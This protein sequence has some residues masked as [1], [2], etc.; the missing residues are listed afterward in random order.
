MSYVDIQP[1]CNDIV[2]LF[3][4][5]FVDLCFISMP[6]LYTPFYPSLGSPPAS[7]GFNRSAFGLLIMS[8]SEYKV[9]YPQ[10]PF[11]MSSLIPLWRFFRPLFT[12]PNHCADRFFNSDSTACSF[13]NRL[14]S[15]LLSGR[16]YHPIPIT[17][18]IS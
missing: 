15:H 6:S 8:L 16:R 10:A 13:D 11:L 5:Y 3:V 12:T 9:I 14:A 4:G 17:V 18:G 2:L 7:L 1:Y